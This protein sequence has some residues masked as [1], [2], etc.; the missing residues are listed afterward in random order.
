MPP[1][2]TAAAPAR[3]AA[4]HRPGHAPVRSQPPLRVVTPGRREAR[5]DAAPAPRRRLVMFVS[6][7]LVVG[8]LLTVV[9][10]QALLANGQVRLNAIQHQ[11]V[12]E[13]AAH[14]QAELGVSTLETPSRIV[15][16]ASSRGM[17][18]PSQVTELPY[19]SL[20]TP[21]PTPKVTP[22]PAVTTATT[23][24]TSTTVPATTA[25]STTVPS[26]T[27]CAC[28]RDMRLSARAPYHPAPRLHVHPALRPGRP[29]AHRRGRHFAHPGWHRP[30]HDGRRAPARL[31]VSARG[32]GSGSG[33]GSGA[34]SGAASGAGHGVV[35]A[36]RRPTRHGRVS[37]STAEFD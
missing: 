6:I 21:L 2:A 37:P 26:T 4:P 25:T 34:A 1:P 19:A 28:R 5:R 8:A 33:N 14:R 29:S 15:G 30:R 17:I 36:P 23:P 20:A 10:G 3:R 31:L 13:Q 24:A 16:A 9:I 22:A 32:S 27:P 35:A 18:H 12:L 7:A 11:L